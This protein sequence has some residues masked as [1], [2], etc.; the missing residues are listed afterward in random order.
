MTHLMVVGFQPSGTPVRFNIE[1]VDDINYLV[2]SGI[3]PDTLTVFERTEEPSKLYSTDEFFFEGSLGNYS[4]FRLFVTRQ[5]GSVFELHCENKEEV[6]KEVLK[7][8]ASDAGCSH[9][10]SKGMKVAKFEQ[11]LN[12][13]TY[14]QFLNSRGI[15]HH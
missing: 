3:N 14:T 6:E 1:C 11:P 8:M 2:E 12:R 9:H 4:Y 10:A 5:S 13:Y 7:I 15:L